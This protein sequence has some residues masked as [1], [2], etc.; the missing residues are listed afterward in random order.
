M[1]RKILYTWASAITGL[2]GVGMLLGYG[3]GNRTS[4]TALWIGGI[5]VIVGAI[6]VGMAI[7]AHKEQVVRINRND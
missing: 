4:N 6:L 5:L 2:I 3:L 1:T 7:S